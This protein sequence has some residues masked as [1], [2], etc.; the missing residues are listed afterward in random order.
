MAINR[1]IQRDPIRAVFGPLKRNSY[2]ASKLP[3]RASILRPGVQV[4]QKRLGSF[5]PTF[6][7]GLSNGSGDARKCQ[8]Y[9]F[10]K[11]DQDPTADAPQHFLYFLPLPQG[12]GSFLPGCPLPG[13]SSSCERTQSITLAG[14]LRCCKSSAI[15]LMYGSM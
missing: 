11:A 6:R 7:D 3:A 2:C 10:A 9:R 1:S 8:G 12:Q 15:N 4:L 14:A 13:A 5:H